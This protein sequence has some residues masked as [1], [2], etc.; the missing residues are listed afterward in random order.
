MS[1]FR[2]VLDTNVLISAGLTPA[3]IARRVV[4]W[5]YAYGVALRSA[6]TLAESQSRSLGRPK[7]DR[8]VDR[9]VRETYVADY[10]GRSVPIPV[11][12][13]LAVCSDPDDDRFAEL[14]V[15]GRADVLVTGNTRDFPPT[16]EGVPV[17]TPAA[18]V[19][20]YVEG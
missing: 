11:T 4:E 13:R 15:D 6:A 10:V 5:T 16:V 2:V 9:D 19:E 18:F 20:A 8:Y 12:T 3:G 1:R 14:A 7:F 17:L